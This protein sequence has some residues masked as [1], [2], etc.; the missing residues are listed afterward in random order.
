M[1]ICCKHLTR[2]E[3][4]S[5]MGALGALDQLG[6]NTAQLVIFLKLKCHVVNQETFSLNN[7]FGL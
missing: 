2:R 5:G 3:D 7:I 1:N 4:R 6:Y